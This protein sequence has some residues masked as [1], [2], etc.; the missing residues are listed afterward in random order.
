[1]LFCLASLWCALTHDMS[2]LIAARFFPGLAGPCCPV[3]LPGVF[4]AAPR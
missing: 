2:Q 3:P 4:T 1:M